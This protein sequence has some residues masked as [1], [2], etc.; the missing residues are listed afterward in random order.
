MEVT[1]KINISSPTGR[2]LVR[3]LEKHTKV[4][5]LEYPTDT[6]LIPE[7]A[8]PLAKGVDQLWESLK[9]KLGYDLREK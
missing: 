1:A 8:V 6:E 4:V 9:N 5:E 7:G 2:R 3:E